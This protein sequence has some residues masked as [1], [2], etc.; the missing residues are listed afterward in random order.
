M[1]LEVIEN[2]NHQTSIEELKTVT[3][4]HFMVSHSTE[5]GSKCIKAVF[6]NNTIGFEVYYNGNL[7]T[8]YPTLLENAIGIYNSIT[9]ND[10]K[11]FKYIIENKLMVLDLFHEGTRRDLYNEVKDFP[12]QYNYKDDIF[13]IVHKDDKN[14]RVVRVAK[15]R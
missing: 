5:F 7:M 1:D 2:S 11:T 9:L 6:T 13:I 4:D 15:Q 10:I 3:F 14:I 12:A 8:A